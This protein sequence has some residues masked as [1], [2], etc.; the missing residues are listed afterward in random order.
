MTERARTATG[1]VAAPE[2]PAVGI[3]ATETNGDAVARA[4]LRAGAAGYDVFVAEVD[5]SASGA[6][7]ARDIGVETISIDARDPDEDQVI[8][9]D[10]A[11]DSDEGDSDD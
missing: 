8:G 6:Q 9:V 5:E 7:L 4:V 11:R 2:R 3:V 1:A 10:V